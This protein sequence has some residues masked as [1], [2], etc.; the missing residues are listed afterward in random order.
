[1][2]YQRIHAGDTIEAI[3]A[4]AWNALV[5]DLENR[6]LPSLPFD[7]S[8]APGSRT[9]IYIKNIAPSTIPSFG[10]LG[11]E[12]PLYTPSAS[13]NALTFF[14]RHPVLRGTI[15]AASVHRSKFVI[16]H[17]PIKAGQIGR[18]YI[19]GLIPVKLQI[20]SA[21]HTHADVEDGNTLRLRS[22]YVGA[23]EI[24]WKESGTGVKNALI[25]YPVLDW[26]VIYGKMEEEILP[27]ETKNMRVWRQ[28]TSTADIEPVKLAWTHGNQKISVNKQVVAEWKRD[29]QCWSIARAECEP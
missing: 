13:A 6:Q 15:P 25:R 19:Q 3:S 2:P 22:G 20:V 26:A 8:T 11:I 1:V 10:V 24:V 9:A 5:S 29:D 17:K 27:G 23:A 21:N 4:R 14:Q 16:P 28:G 12:G 7:F 18:A